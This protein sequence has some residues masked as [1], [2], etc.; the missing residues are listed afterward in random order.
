MLNNAARVGVRVAIVDSTLQGSTNSP[1]ATASCTWSN[2][3]TTSSTNLA[4]IKACD[5]ITNA[6]LCG[7]ASVNLALTED[8]S[9]PGV[10]SGDSIR[11]TVQGNFVSVVPNL[12]ALSFGLFQSPL[13]MTT[14]ASMRYE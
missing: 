8:V 14:S 2:S 3:C 4:I 9:P 1:L 10:S 7:T 11:V 12:S 6:G 5:N 13:T